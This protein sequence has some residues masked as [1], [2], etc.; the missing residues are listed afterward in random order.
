MAYR[1]K[2]DLDKLLRKLGVGTAS[3]SASD[4]TP[5]SNKE[6]VAANSA[7]SADRAR[8]QEMD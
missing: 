1:V 3:S 4:S 7:A 6:G 2:E 8:M 5:E